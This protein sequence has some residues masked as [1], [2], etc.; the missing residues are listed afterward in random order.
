MLLAHYEYLQVL[1][2]KSRYYKS[3]QVIHSQEQFT[4]QYCSHCNGRNHKD[5]DGDWQQVSDKQKYIRTGSN[6]PDLNLV[7]CSYCKSVF[8]KDTNDAFNIMRKGIYDVQQNWD[9]L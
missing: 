7:Q 4:S 2:S 6:T 9:T 5:A 3:S 8:I 1:A